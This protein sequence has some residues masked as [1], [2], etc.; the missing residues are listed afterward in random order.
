MENLCDQVIDQIKTDIDA[1][2]VTAIEELILRFTELK[3]TESDWVIEL[4]TSFLPEKESVN[5]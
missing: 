3:T 1:G 4:L 2:D 5:E